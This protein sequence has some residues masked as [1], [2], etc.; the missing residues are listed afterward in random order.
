MQPPSLLG[1]QLCIHVKGRVL[2]M[3]WKKKG[4]KQG[5]RKARD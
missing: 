1:L 4:K 2:S 3:T 5:R